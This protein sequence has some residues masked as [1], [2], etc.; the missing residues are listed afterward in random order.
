MAHPRKTVK[1]QHSFKRPSIS[2]RQSYDVIVIGA[3]MG[4]SIVAA[5][6]AE[7]GLR[8]LVLEKGRDPVAVP[9]RKGLMARALK[10]YDNRTGER[11]PEELLVRR[12]EN[13]RYREVSPVLGLGPGGSGRIYGAALGRASRA[14][15]E[16]DFQPNQ[17]DGGGE[18]ALMNDW[19]VAY[20]E[21]LPAYREA[22]AMLGLV[23]E[24][25]PLDPDDDAELGVPP[26]LSP[27]HEALANRL[28]A[29]GRHP[30]RMHVGIAYKPGCN[31]CQGITCA[32]NCKAHGYNRAL[33]PAMAKQAPVALEKGARLTSISKTAE[34]WTVAYSDEQGDAREV[35]A[36]ALVLAAGA[37]NTPRI[38]QDKVA[39]PIGEDLPSLVGRGLMFHA[40][41]I[42]AVTP[43]DPA[44]LYG[45]R[46]VL[47]FRD[48]YMDGAMPL[49]ECQSMG[50]VAKSGMIA[51]F[52]KNRLRL[53]GI[54]AGNF[55]TLATRFASLFAERMFE[56][57]ELFTGI[58]QDLPFADNR[59]TTEIDAQGR[60]RIAITYRPREDMVARTKHFR[61]LVRDAFAPLDVRFISPVGEPN[62]GHPMGTCRMGSDPAHS[63]VDAEGRVWGQSGL[64][65][66]DAS[67]FPSSLGINPALTVAAHALRVARAVGAKS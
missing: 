50:L 34:G 24:R 45:V 41:E 23:G 40:L 27:A 4:G 31:E 57:A 37:L 48:H 26:P 19:P 2:K 21:F 58:L 63:V 18:D 9:R 62:L 67:V 5:R 59:V 39:L 66:A 61:K 55:G 64:F 52:L 20:E 32:R 6:C 13:S 1:R 25:D 11:W 46:K 28:R 49:G 12:D 17:W 7:A 16:C 30:Y 36:G 42:I 35:D 44:Q 65:I 43:P 14:D 38:L 15:F 29:N 3:G 56:G 47:A 54:A 33:M 53:A 10:E 60:E 51:E 8:V 22:E